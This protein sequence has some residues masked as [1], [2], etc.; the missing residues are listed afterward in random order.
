MYLGFLESFGEDNQ[1]SSKARTRIVMTE[2]YKAAAFRQEPW[3]AVDLEKEK[4]PQIANEKGMGGERGNLAAQMVDI[5]KNL[6][7]AAGRAKETPK[8]QELLS[9]LDEQLG[10][11]ET[12]CRWLRDEE[13]RWQIRTYNSDSRAGSSAGHQS[14]HSTRR[15]G[16]F[17]ESLA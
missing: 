8:K 13:A 9:V 1:Y 6:A 12:P 5:A 2:L 15:G 14:Q 4:L 17:H 7:D 10:L 11:M 3:Q 16:S